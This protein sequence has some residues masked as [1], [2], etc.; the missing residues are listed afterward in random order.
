MVPKSLVGFT[1]WVASA[2]LVGGLLGLFI[3]NTRTPKYSYEGLLKVPVV[4]QNPFADIQEIGD[5]LE[6]RYKGEKAKTPDGVYLAS[7]DLSRAPRSMVNLKVVGPSLE[8]AK[9]GLENMVKAIRE[10]FGGPHQKYVT[11]LTQEIELLKK[12]EESLLNSSANLR[13]LDFQRLRPEEK[14]PLQ[15]YLEENERTRRQ[16]QTDKIKQEGLLISADVEPIRLVDSKPSSLRPVSPRSLPNFVFAAFTAA[17]LAAGVLRLASYFRT[18]KVP[19]TA[20][21]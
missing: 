7:F 9:S 13:S 17:C 21:A 20:K 2:A 18:I 11:V 16:L 1:L 10:K 5:F 14:I 4:D 19:I 3:G 12:N 15:L 8:A 6:F